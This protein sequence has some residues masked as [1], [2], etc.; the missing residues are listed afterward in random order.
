MAG[1]PPLKPAAWHAEKLLSWNADATAATLKSGML[2]SC[3]C[4]SRPAPETS[5]GGFGVVGVP[6]P[7][8]DPAFARKSPATHPVFASDVVTCHH[9]Y[10]FAVCGPPAMVNDVPEAKH[11]IAVADVVGCA[12]RFV[13]PVPV[14]TTAS[15][16]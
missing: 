8:P 15:P 13:H 12:R 14:I 7:P 16:G 10:P 11:A 6:V 2:N 3:G 1:Q 9:V 4:H 5:A